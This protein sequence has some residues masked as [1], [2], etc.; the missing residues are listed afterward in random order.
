MDAPKHA[1]PTKGDYETGK[2]PV[3][4]H[5]DV[6]E[7]NNKLDVEYN[8]PITSSRN[9]KWCASLSGRLRLCSLSTAESHCATSSDC[10]LTAS[11]A[12]YGCAL[13]AQAFNADRRQPSSTRNLNSNSMQVVL[14]FSQRHCYCGSWSLGSA[15]SFFVPGLGW[16]YGRPHPVMAYLF[17][18]LVAAGQDA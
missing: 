11:P 6:M 3:S 13:H 5:G 14:S 16:W 15:L 12:L 2:A 9:A 10:S 17:V 7:F 18:H 8:L 1:P 4:K